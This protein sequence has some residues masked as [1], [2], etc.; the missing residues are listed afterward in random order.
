LPREYKQ[1]IEQIAKINENSNNIVIDKNVFNQNE[2]ELHK[3]FTFENTGKPDIYMF[4]ADNEYFQDF[5]PIISPINLK[6]GLYHN[7]TKNNFSIDLI[8]PYEMRSQ[9]FERNVDLND[10][11]LINDISSINEDIDD[12]KQKKKLSLDLDIVD[13]S[14]TGRIFK[15]SLDMSYDHLCFITP[16]NKESPAIVRK[17]T[18]LISPAAFCISPKSAFVI[19][20]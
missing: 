3:Q 16:L 15:E 9:L 8:S 18:M 10:K 20:K 13:K 7:I 5:Q 17:K 2:E 12:N 14:D 6:K 4:D 1:D 11:I 19:R